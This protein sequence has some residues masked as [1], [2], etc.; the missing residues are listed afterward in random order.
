M[1]GRE[2]SNRCKG[3]GTGH[4]ITRSSP[5]QRELIVRRGGVR[6]F[7]A[8]RNYAFLSPTPYGPSSALL[9]KE[10]DLEDPIKLLDLQGEKTLEKKKDV[11]QR[12]GS[13]GRIMSGSLRSLGYGEHTASVLSRR[14]V[15]LTS[16]GI[17]PILPNKLLPM[18]RKYKEKLEPPEIP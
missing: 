18:R 1:V 15:K 7:R 2:I 8:R 17:A 10:G 5:R 14:K 13:L 16:V 12:L 4:S 11:L 6:L 3:W 9:E